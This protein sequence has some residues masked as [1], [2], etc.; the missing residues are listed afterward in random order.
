MSILDLQAIRKRAEAATE[1]PWQAHKYSVSSEHTKSENYAG[2]IDDIC[3]LNDGEYI[4]NYNAEADAEFIAHARQDVPALI[5]EVERLREALEEI[6]SV[7]GKYI[8]RGSDADDA[9]DIAREALK[10][11]EKELRR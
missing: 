2:E 8:N 3:S 6:V 10:D 1:G 4:E 11:G 5:A 7:D 9:F